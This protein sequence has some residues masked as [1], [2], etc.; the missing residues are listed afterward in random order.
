MVISLGTNFREMQYNSKKTFLVKVFKN[1]ISKMSNCF[2]L[3]VLNLS[4]CD[5]INTWRMLWSKTHI[6]KWQVWFVFV[7]IWLYHRNR[8]RMHQHLIQLVNNDAITTMFYNKCID[9]FRF[10]FTCTFYND[11]FKGWCKPI[12]VTVKLKHW[13][14]GAC[15]Y[16]VTYSN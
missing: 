13:C 4:N 14:M 12:W 7:W 16:F 11:Y 2:G 8:F 9:W 10:P 3:N 1:G 5:E 6:L 15:A